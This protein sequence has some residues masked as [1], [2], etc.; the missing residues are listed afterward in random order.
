MA[1]LFFYRSLLLAS[2]LLGEQTWASS[3][4][5]LMFITIEEHWVSPALTQSFEA[6]PA[7]QLNHINNTAPGDDFLPRILDVGPLRLANMTANNIRKQ[8]VSHVSD[9]AVLD[10][11]NLIKQAN[12][13]LA[14]AI[15]NNTDR[16]AGFAFLP[17]VFPELAAA[18]LERC[19]KKL[20]FVGALI[21]TH[22]NNH[23]FYDGAAYRPFWAKAVELDVPIYLH[24]TFPRPEEF[25]NA[26]AG[27]YAPASPSD[28]SLETASH[29][30]TT[31]WGWH[32]DVGLHF[33]RLY[34]AGVFEEFPTLKIVLGH[35][36]EM[37]PFM[38]ERANVFLSGNS[39]R[40]SLIDTY[41]RNVWITTA[42]FF[43]LNPLGTV[44]RNTKIDRILYS[45][46]YPYGNSVSGKMFMNNLKESGL[47]SEAEW[48]MIAYKN[49]EA[50]LKLKKR[51]GTKSQS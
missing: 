8:V 22:L 27:I 47:V 25:L 14:A 3:N 10:Q 6:N 46:D 42:G 41:A 30:G 9:P 28:F 13:Q 17:M 16:F 2:L 1:R 26:G 7:A 39:S 15:A 18:E 43:S 33:L 12:D 5:D 51:M 29:L 31:A 49:A 50:L 19:V 4:D 34:A 37:V 20:G 48:E 24:P 11:P 21:D 32:Q 35:M 38:L 40:L 44:L 45:V 36:G 23:T